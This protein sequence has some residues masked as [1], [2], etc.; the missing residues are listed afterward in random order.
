MGFSGTNT[1][2]AC[3]FCL[4]S[5]PWVIKQYGTHLK[6]SAAMVRLRLYDVLALLPPESYEGQSLSLSFHYFHSLP[7]LI[8]QFGLQKLAG[9][10]RLRVYEFISLLPSKAFP[11]EGQFLCLLLFCY[12]VANTCS[13]FA[14]HPFLYVIPYSTVCFCVFIICLLYVSL[15][16]VEP[17]SNNK[18][19]ISI[20]IVRYTYYIFA[21]HIQMYKYI[22]TEH[23]SMLT[24][25]GFVQRDCL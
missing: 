5:L 9:R 2:L 21:K 16:I 7:W 22:F 20:N 6:A 24:C 18:D 11:L 15:S 12:C 23:K 13:L 8:S 10:F 17:I 19:Y 14:F 1:W 25:Q 4:H 3:M